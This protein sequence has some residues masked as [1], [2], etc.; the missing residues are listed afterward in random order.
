MTW[1]DGA[2]H[3]EGLAGRGRGDGGVPLA[4]GDGE[5]GHQPVVVPVIGRELAWTLHYITLHYN[6]ITRHAI[7]SHIHVRTSIGSRCDVFRYK[8]H[9][10]PFCRKARI[11][12]PIKSLPVLLWYCCTVWVWIITNCS[13]RAKTSPFIKLLLQIVAASQ[14]ARHD[15]GEE[16]QRSAKWTLAE[17]KIVI[18]RHLLDILALARTR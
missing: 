9:S 5:G 10:H 14:I 13:L 1:H 18:F 12:C 8:R 4:G 3:L 6:Y 17:L 15:D 11:L 16:N 2:A 7:T